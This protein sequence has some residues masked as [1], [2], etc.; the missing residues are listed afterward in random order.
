MQAVYKSN[1]QYFRI[2]DKSKLG[3]FVNCRGGKLKMFLA[4]YTKL[5]QSSDHYKDH[6]TRCNNKI[7]KAEFPLTSDICVHNCVAVSFVHAAILSRIEKL[8]I[9]F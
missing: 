2:P 6:I 5:D 7:L 3:G 1:I 4:R 8:P 9:H